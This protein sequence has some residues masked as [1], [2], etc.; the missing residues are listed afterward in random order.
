M[1]YS[2][3]LGYW[4]K[5]IAVLKKEAQLRRRMRYNETHKRDPQKLVHVLIT[6]GSLALAAHTVLV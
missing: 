3:F 6:F 2:S 5:P 4:T 1:I